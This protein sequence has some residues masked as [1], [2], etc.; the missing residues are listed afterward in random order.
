MSR[1]V[2]RDERSAV[3]DPIGRM[4][5]YHDQS[6]SSLPFLLRVSARM[7]LCRKSGLPGGA[8]RLVDLRDEVARSAQGLAAAR[9]AIASGRAR[10]KAD[11]FVAFARRQKGAVS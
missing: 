8:S 7:F 11:E 3:S 2:Q 1:I 4:G 10:A 6:H 5:R 9:A